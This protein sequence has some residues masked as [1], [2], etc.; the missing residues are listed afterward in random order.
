MKAV[1]RPGAW[2]S[3]SRVRGR[4][5]HD[6]RDPPGSQTAICSGDTLMNTKQ[7]EDVCRWGVGGSTALVFPE[8]GVKIIAFADSSALVGVESLGSGF[9]VNKAAGKLEVRVGDSASRIVG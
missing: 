8:S 2:I 6:W 4:P 9:K 3:E 5:L 1:R 7:P